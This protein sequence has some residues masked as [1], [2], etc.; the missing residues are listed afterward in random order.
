MH[1]VKKEKSTDQ[2]NNLKPITLTNCNLKIIIK[3]AKLNE[4]GHG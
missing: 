4:Q 1:L 2:I 3:T